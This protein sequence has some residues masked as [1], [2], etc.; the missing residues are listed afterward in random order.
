MNARS[1]S[2]R[3]P[4]LRILGLVLVSL[5]AACSEAAAPDP[6]LLEM[7]AGDDQE[8][9]I[10]TTV[11]DPLVVRVTGL[12]GI[13]RED[14]SVEWTVAEGG[15]IE[16]LRGST[17]ADG[18][19]EALWTLGAE[20]GEQ[21]ARSTAGGA[22]VTFRALATPVPPEDWA[23]ALEVR[24]T[25]FVEAE[26]IH[27]RLVVVN[28]WAGTMRIRF[29]TCYVAARLYA[30]NGER[31]PDAGFQPQTWCDN[32]YFGATRPPGDSLGFFF[33]TPSAPVEPG[34]YTVRFEF[35][36]TLWVNERATFLSAQET[37]VLVG[38]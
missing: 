14:I 6:V 8:A 9:Q 18:R 37:S 7:A 3:M 35:R 30:A 24:P 12:D 15:S 27:A 1:R 16:P 23:D 10:G 33:E 11:T 25:A 13:V 29:P 17:D 19:A 26:W 5:A 38:G 4:L 36:D 31:A 2:P 21:L 28:R 20:P 34:T 22:S 32:W